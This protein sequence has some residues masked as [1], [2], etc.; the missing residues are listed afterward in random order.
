MARVL[1]AEHHNILRGSSWWAGMEHECA[2]C[3][4]LHR[5]SSWGETVPESSPRAQ[6]LEATRHCTRGHPRWGHCANCHRLRRWFTPWVGAWYRK[7]DIDSRLQIH[8][9]APRHPGALNTAACYSLANAIDVAVDFVF[10]ATVE[11]R[12]GINRQLPTPVT[13]L[14]QA[15]GRTR[16][17]SAT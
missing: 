14:T 4:C 17:L 2:R 6:W 13:T 10:V 16:M 15:K 1:V 5:I 9:I 12:L 3:S 8:V 7:C 11:A